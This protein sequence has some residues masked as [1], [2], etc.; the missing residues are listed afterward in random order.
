M[1]TRLSPIVTGFS[2]TSPTSAF[3]YGQRPPHAFDVGNQ[4]VGKMDDDML[5]RRS[6]RSQLRNIHMWGQ[7]AV[8]DNQALTIKG[9]DGPFEDNWKPDAKTII[10]PLMQSITWLLIIYAIN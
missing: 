8:E 10:K 6:M 7:Q 9:F 1:S 5:C 4:A 3:E 2:A